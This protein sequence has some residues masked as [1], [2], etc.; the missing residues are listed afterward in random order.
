MMAVCSANCDVCKEPFNG[1]EKK[2]KMLPCGHTFCD[3]CLKTLAGRFRGMT[4]PSCRQAW[5]EHPDDLRVCYQLIPTKRE[6]NSGPLAS[7]A[8]ICEE[9]NFE[10]TFWCNSCKKNACKTCIVRVHMNCGIGSHNAIESKLLEGRE[11]LRSLRNGCKDTLNVIQEF[12]TLVKKSVN[13]LSAM[14]NKMEDLD[15]EVGHHTQLLQNDVESNGEDSNNNSEIH[16][17]VNRLPKLLTEFS[18]DA[19]TNLLLYSISKTFLVSFV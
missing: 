16:C 13:Q 19:C 15:T 14:K 5:D 6:E 3:L 4:C 18:Q 17:F 8:S 9:H 2:P 1:D 12:L 11:Q 10:L 7:D